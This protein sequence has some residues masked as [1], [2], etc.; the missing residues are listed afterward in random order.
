MNNQWNGKNDR[1]QWKM[2]FLTYNDDLRDKIVKVGGR[3]IWNRTTESV[4]RQP[5]M[6]Q[7]AQTSKTFRNKKNAIKTCVQGL[8]K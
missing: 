4:K 1:E 6:T 2:G 5:V 3:E 7:V 8:I